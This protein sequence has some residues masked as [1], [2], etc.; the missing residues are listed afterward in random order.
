[1]ALIL[2]KMLVAYAVIFAPE[3]TIPL[4]LLPPFLVV[5]PSEMTDFSVT[6]EV[7]LRLSF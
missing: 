5:P 7:V 1:M 2:W 3:R 6:V 4:L